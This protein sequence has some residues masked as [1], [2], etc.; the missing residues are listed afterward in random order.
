[1][2]IGDGVTPVGIHLHV[3]RR[4]A[5][6][7]KLKLLDVLVVVVVVGV[8][9][10]VLSLPTPSFPS[11]HTLFPTACGLRKRGGGSL[12]FEWPQTTLK[13]LPTRLAWTRLDSTMDIK[14]IYGD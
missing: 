13:L 10:V 11:P 6:G 12:S 9:F 3:A 4:A 7:Q 1:M 8:A 14:W 2:R 5:C